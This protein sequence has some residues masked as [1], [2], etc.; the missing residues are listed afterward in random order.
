[1]SGFD[2]RQGQHRRA[3][4]K[5]W[6]NPAARPLARPLASAFSEIRGYGAVLVVLGLLLR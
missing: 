6:V 2:L 5:G 1:M 4:R 3:A